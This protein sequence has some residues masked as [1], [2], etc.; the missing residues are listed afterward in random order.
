MSD[1]MIQALKAVMKDFTHTPE[2]YVQEAHEGA[3]YLYLPTPLPRSL[4]MYDRDLVWVAFRAMIN[5]WAKHLSAT[6]MEILRP[7]GG[8]DAERDDTGART[9]SSP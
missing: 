1:L 7:P 6:K 9:P 2:K 8:V 5:A 3:V 4:Y